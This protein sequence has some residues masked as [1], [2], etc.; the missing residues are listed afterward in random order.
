M[1]AQNPQ[2]NLENPKIAVLIPAYNEEASLPVVLTELRE[3]FPQADAI[4]INDA[5]SDDTAA[6]AVSHG[7]ICLSHPTN[8]GV[9]G[10]MKTGYLYAYD[11]GYDIAIQFDAD[12][13]H[14]AITITDLV[15]PLLAGSADMVIGSRNM[16]EKV[17]FRFQAG[18]LTGSRLIRL[19]LKL[20]FR[21]NITDPTSGFRAVNRKAMKFFSLHY[22]YFWLADTVEAIVELVRHGMTI[23]EVPVKMRTRKHGSSAAGLSKG[24]LATTCVMIA[25]LVDLFE[26]RYHD[27]SE[28]CQ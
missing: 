21:V 7:A 15:A 25:I 11:N 4:V 20:F 2:T 17:N 8:L 3:K 27:F 22:P 14:R 6:V 9:G 18:R 26:S 12:A 16:G 24:I 28:E 10:A 1:A 5:S 23:V 19:T 13:Q